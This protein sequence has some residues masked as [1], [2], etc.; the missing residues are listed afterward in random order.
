MH[1][2]DMNPLR[3]EKYLPLWLFLM[4]P[5]GIVSHV[6]VPLGI[7]SHH[8]VPLRIVSHHVVPLEMVSLL[9]VPLGIVSHLVVPF[10]FFLLTDFI[11]QC[12]LLDSPLR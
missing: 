2:I 1:C 6:V 12:L 10:G 8:V 4:D 5:F 11:G 9:V 3:F 7:V